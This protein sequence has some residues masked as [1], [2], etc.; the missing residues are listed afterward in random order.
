VNECKPLLEGLVR[1]HELI[2]VVAKKGLK[3]TWSSPLEGM[4]NTYAL[5]NLLQ[6]RGM[7]WM[8]R[9]ACKRQEAVAAVAGCP[10]TP[11]GRNN[12]CDDD[13][14]EGGGSVVVGTPVGVKTAGAGGVGTP[15]GAGMKSPKSPGPVLGEAAPAVATTLRHAAAGSVYGLC[16]PIPDA[17]ARLLSPL[18]QVP[19]NDV[20][21]HE[22]HPMT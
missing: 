17:N 11:L 1:K 12:N 5:D 14:D 8:L 20:T 19:P 22:S 9:A 10:R 3:F 16:L 4:G 6:E 18:S 2:E 13:E 21:E 15:G 7:A